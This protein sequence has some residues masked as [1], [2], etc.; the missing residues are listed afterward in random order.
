MF[1]FITP[2]IQVL[3]DSIEVNRSA[4]G[5]VWNRYQCYA[6]VF[7]NSPN[8][9]SIVLLCSTALL[10][11]R[12][13]EKLPQTEIAAVLLLSG[14]VVGP[15]L[16]HAL[17]FAAAY[18]WAFAIAAVVWYL[19]VVITYETLN[20]V[21]KLNMDSENNKSHFY[22]FII[23]YAGIVVVLLFATGVPTMILAYKDDLKYMDS[24]SLI[25]HDRN[26]QEFLAHQMKAARW[27]TLIHYFI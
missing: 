4:S 3:I 20:R 12:D 26:P 10:K 11:L 19:T 13:R 22:H 23:R 25:E 21:F 27:Y 6:V 18:P 2:L 9:G 5:N 15:L 1:K 24:L 7:S 17:P 8:V 16:T 14:I